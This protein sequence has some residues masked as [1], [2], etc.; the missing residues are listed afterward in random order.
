MT[1]STLPLLARRG[2]GLIYLLVRLAGGSP[3]AALGIVAVV[4]IGAYAYSQMGDE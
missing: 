2:G 3:L 4:G 1:A